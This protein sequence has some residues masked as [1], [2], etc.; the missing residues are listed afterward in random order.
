MGKGALITS[1]VYS[2]RSVMG[3]LSTFRNCEWFMCTVNHK[4]GLSIFSVKQYL[5]KKQ[6]I[7]GLFKNPMIEGRQRTYF[8]VY[9]Q[10]VANKYIY[11][12]LHV[13]H[14]PIEL[15]YRKYPFLPGIQNVTW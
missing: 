12:T 8:I 5:A 13:V 6:T 10:E 14:S 3:A 7:L 11:I 1:R 2:L 9:G 4:L 15:Y